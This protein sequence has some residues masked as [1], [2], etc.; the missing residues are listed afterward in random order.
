MIVNDDVR[1]ELARR[2]LAREMAPNPEM[3][4]AVMQ[5]FTLLELQKLHETTDGEGK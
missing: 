2:R 1:F 4:K 3:I 5:T